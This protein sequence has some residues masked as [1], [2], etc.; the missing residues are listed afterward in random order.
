[1]SSSRRSRPDQFCIHRVDG[2]N[3]TLLTTVEY[4]P[5]HKLSV[6]NLYAGLQPMNFWEEIVQPDSVPTEEPTKL[7][8]NAA[9]LTGSAVTQEYHVMIQ[10]GLKFSYLT[11]GFALVLLHVPYD[12][13]STLYYHLCEPNME[14]DPDDNCSF[15]QPLTAIAR[16]LCLCLMSFSA[17]FR[18]QNPLGSEYSP[19]GSSARTISEYLLSSSPVGSSTQRRGMPTRSRAQ[20]AP[21]TIDPDNSPD[22]DTDPAPG[23]RKRGFSQVTSSPSSPLSPSVQRSAR[24][25]GSRHNESGRYQHSAQF[26]TQRC[27]LGLQ[28]GGQLDDDCP[29]IMLH[30]QGRTSSRHLIDAKSLVQ[31]IKQQLDENLDRDCMPIGGCG[32]SGAPFKITCTTYGYTVVGKGTTAYLWNKV[33]RE[34]DIYCILWQVQGSAVPVFL[35][36]IDLA[37]IYFLHGAGQIHHMLLMAWGGEPISKINHTKAIRREILRSQKKIRS[38]GV[39]HQD[40]RPDNLL[41]NTELGRVLIIDFH[42]SKLDVR[43][44]KKRMRLREKLLCRAEEHRRKR[45]RAGYK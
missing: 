40:L 5:P 13:P 3:S 44:T 39:L 41:W 2:D 42:H 33:K 29:N 36:A 7:K 14:I 10:E 30:Q 4:K 12:E 28:Q 26:C 6:E 24:Q 31:Q 9:R 23:G 32:A 8:Y 16:V 15:E 1:M 22:S 18:D 11:N 27:L 21:N 19:S 20:C 38:L 34:A 25:T 43:P 45:L 35:G 37:K 17:R